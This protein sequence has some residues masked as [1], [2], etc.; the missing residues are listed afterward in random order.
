MEDVPQL[1]TPGVIAAELGVPLDRVLYVLQ[2]RS[3]DIRPIGRAGCLRIYD[4]AAVE[5]VRNELHEM[6]AANHLGG[7]L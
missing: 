3:R 7:G 2:K 4:R 1:R 5:A 6:G